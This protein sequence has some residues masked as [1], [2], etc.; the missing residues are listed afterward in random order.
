LKKKKILP[1][2]IN[3]RKMIPLALMGRAIREISD[4]MYMI[5]KNRI[6][7]GIDISQ[8]VSVLYDF[9]LE[10]FKYAN[11]TLEYRKMDVEDENPSILFE[12]MWYI[13]NTTLPMTDFAFID[14]VPVILVIAVKNTEKNT[15]GP[16]MTRNA[17]LYTLRCNGYPEKLRNIIKKNFE[18][19]RE[20]E[21]QTR[22]TKRTR[23]IN[24]LTLNDD[25]SKRIARR[26]FNNVFVPKD[27][28]EQICTNIDNFLNQKQWYRDNVIPYH[29]GIMLY[30]PAGTG[31]TSTAQ[32]IADYI[33]HSHMYYVSGDDV[34]YLPSMVNDSIGSFD[35]YTNVF[36]IED[37]DC[38]LDIHRTSR[39]SID[40][41]RS[42]D[43]KDD[44]DHM[45]LASLLNSIDGVCAPFNVVFIFT[46]N[47]IE[48]LDPALLRPGR[49]DLCV[50]IKPVCLETFTEFM[51]HH[52]GDIKIPKTLKIKDGITF[53]KLQ[54]MVMNHASPKEIMDYVKEK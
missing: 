2:P 8:H 46:T 21:E 19:S 5:G 32:A 49:I 47:H 23:T 20:K 4:T 15:V 44:K 51:I 13:N 26:S 50:E 40:D 16:K 9:L 25:K 53:A 42:K 41:V 30:G 33:P 29:F 22:Q 34:L 14:D 52:F 24:V 45:G 10:H 38:G 35:K 6:T 43:N 27:I 36:I 54:L 7:Y 37:V 1:M 18:L 3:P 48:K 28:R 17:Y 12:A 11:S 39:R 31:K